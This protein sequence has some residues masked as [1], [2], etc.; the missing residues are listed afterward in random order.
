M[1]SIGGFVIPNAIEAL[2]IFPKVI[3]VILIT[4]CIIFIT[5]MKI[6]LS[7]G[8]MTMVVVG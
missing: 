4:I 5:M 3:L 6:I 8:T 2:K 7:I 1:M